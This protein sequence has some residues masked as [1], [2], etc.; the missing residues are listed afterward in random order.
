MQTHGNIH[1]PTQSN[2]Y[3]RNYKMKKFYQKQQPKIFNLTKTQTTTLISENI[4]YSRVEHIQ[5]YGL[6]MKIPNY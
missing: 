4:N 1:G 6:Q 3:I 5:I 2:P